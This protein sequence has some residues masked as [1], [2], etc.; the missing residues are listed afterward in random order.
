[1]AVPSASY[2]PAHSSNRPKAR[3]SSPTDSGEESMARW[4]LDPFTRPEMPGDTRLR[5]HVEEI[6]PKIAAIHGPAPLP[7]AAPRPRGGVRHGAEPSKSRSRSNVSLPRPQPHR[8]RS[9]PRGRT[10][11]PPPPPR[12][13][14]MLRNSPIAAPAL[15]ISQHSRCSTHATEHVS[16]PSG[17]RRA[18]RPVHKPEKDAD[19]SRSGENGWRPRANGTTAQS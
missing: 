15:W 16:R 1:M 6:A 17:H 19:F 7:H 11:M 10:T 8:S 12:L 3:A 4:G 13:L 18:G 14:R 9:Q 2:R 5:R